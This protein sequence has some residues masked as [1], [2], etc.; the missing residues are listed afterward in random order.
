MCLRLCG[1]KGRMSWERVQRG[2]WARAV[3]QN[4]AS[5]GNVRGRGGSIDTHLGRR[6]ISTMDTATTVDPGAWR[7]LAAQTNVQV[8]GREQ[9]RS[10]R[11]AYYRLT[12]RVSVL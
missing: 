2:M 3:W 5:E 9:A 8:F 7:R 1:K 11:V 10:V 4:Q 6:S 12:C